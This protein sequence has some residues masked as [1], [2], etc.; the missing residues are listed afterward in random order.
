[1]QQKKKVVSTHPRKVRSRA[2]SFDTAPESVVIFNRDRIVRSNKARAIINGKRSTLWSLFFAC[3]RGVVAL[4]IIVHAPFMQTSAVIDFVDEP[5]WL[6]FRDSYR[7]LKRMDFQEGRREENSG[8]LCVPRKIR[9]P[10]RHEVLSRKVSIQ[11]SRTTLENKE[12]LL[13]WNSRVRPNRDSFHSSPYERELLFFEGGGDRAIV[14]LIKTCW[15]TK[16]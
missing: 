14:R 12:S 10:Y 4:L 9:V 6:I 5:T 15:A 1:M 8:N 7:N 11:E 13:P 2:P 3:V 16:L